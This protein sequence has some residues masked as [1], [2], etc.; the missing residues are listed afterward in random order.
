MTISTS[1]LGD[2]HERG[3]PGLF[4]G[5]P[6]RVRDHI[7]RARNLPSHPLGGSAADGCCRPAARFVGGAGV[8]DQQR[9]VALAVA[10]LP[11]PW[12]SGG[13]LPMRSATLPLQPP[14][15]AGAHPRPPR[16]PCRSGLRL[17][18]PEIYHQPVRSARIRA[19]PSKPRPFDRVR[20]QVRVV[21]LCNV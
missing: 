19:D 17:R 1:H 9:R 21:A 2:H 20:D 3:R 12:I 10:S 16:P 8:S 5:W 4:C 14:R 11:A 6:L 13:R 7:L 15:H 18:L